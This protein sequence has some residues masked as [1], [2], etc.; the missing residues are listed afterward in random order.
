[1]F[2]THHAPVRFE[3]L[4]R[5]LICENAAAHRHHHASGK[6]RNQGHGDQELEE[7][8]ALSRAL[9]WPTVILRAYQKIRSPACRR[10]LRN[11]SSVKLRRVPP[12]IHHTSSSTRSTPTEPR[13]VPRAASNAAMRARHPE[14]SPPPHAALNS[15]PIYSLRGAVRS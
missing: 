12:S 2:Y 15:P 14:R 4:R 13:P 6:H 7:R 5:F 1:M 10:F 8:N 3:A 9:L 11:P